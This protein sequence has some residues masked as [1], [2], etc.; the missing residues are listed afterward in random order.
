MLV[1]GVETLIFPIKI[2][3]FTIYFNA[4]MKGEVIALKLN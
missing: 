4:G 2:K 1:P 3:E